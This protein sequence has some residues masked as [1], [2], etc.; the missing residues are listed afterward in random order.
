M[1]VLKSLNKMGCNISG[2]YNEYK[3]GKA[4]LVTVRGGP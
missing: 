3:K 2:V 4:I 1:K